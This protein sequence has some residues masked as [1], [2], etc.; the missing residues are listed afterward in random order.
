MRLEGINVN[1]VMGNNPGQPVDVIIVSEYPDRV[2]EVAKKYASQ[3]FGPDVERYDKQ[4]HI[5]PFKHGDAYFS[6]FAMGNAY[7]AH[8]LYLTHVVTLGA[9]PEKQF[10]TVYKAVFRAM[11]MANQD[12][13]TRAE[14]IAV[15]FNLGADA[16]TPEQNARAII[17]AVDAFSRIC[18]YSIVQE[19]VLCTDKE[20][21]DA[22]EKVLAEDSY[23]GFGTQEGQAPFDPD[24]WVVE[25]EGCSFCKD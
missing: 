3:G 22:A 12:T 19:V 6:R 20:A 13:P 16:L 1:I 10:E 8:I 25:D 9:A 23:R 2:S 14:R 17:G 21:M 18:G 7:P 11:C 15:P 24:K 4:V 5:K